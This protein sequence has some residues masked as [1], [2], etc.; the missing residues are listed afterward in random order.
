MELFIFVQMGG[1]AEDVDFFHIGDDAPRI[2]SFD[3]SL[4]T[5]FMKEDADRLFAVVEAGFESL[6]EFNDEVHMLLA[7]VVRER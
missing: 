6:S 2:D 1:L 5:C 4:A 3:A 7:S